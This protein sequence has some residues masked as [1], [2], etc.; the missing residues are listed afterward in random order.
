MAAVSLL[1]L[2]SLAVGVCVLVRNAKRKHRAKETSIELHAPESPYYKSA[3]QPSSRIVSSASPSGWT[4]VENVE[5]HESLGAGHFGIVYRG[6]WNG[7]TAVA[8]KKLK[9]KEELKDF[10][11][12]ASMLQSLNHPNIVRCLG[13][14]VSPSSGEQYIVM[15]FLSK[16]SL[17]RVLVLE[18][19]SIGLLDLMA[20]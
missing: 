5:L 17:D 8:L 6:I 9:S 7:T 20:M 2:V 12:E 14:H 4:I 11:Q 19:K 18:E 16:G 1:I 15:E 13:I 3:T 10:L